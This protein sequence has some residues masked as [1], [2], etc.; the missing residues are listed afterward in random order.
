M[1]WSWLKDWWR[2]KSIRKRRKLQMQRNNAKHLRAATDSDLG[3]G[4]NN[5]PEAHSSANG[6]L[7]RARGKLGNGDPGEND[8]EDDDDEDDVCYCDECIANVNLRF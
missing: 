7:E 1:E 6:Q 2:L 8:D 3:L 5:N 4:G